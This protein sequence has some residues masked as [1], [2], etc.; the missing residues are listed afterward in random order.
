MSLHGIEELSPMGYAAI[1]GSG[2]RRPIGDRPPPPLEVPSLWRECSGI[3]L[4][5]VLL[6]VAAWIFSGC[7]AHV[8]PSGLDLVFAGSFYSHTDE[9]AEGEDDDPG[10]SQWATAAARTWGTSGLEGRIT[11]SSETISITGNGISDNLAGVLGED[12]IQA[13]AGAVACA[14]QPAQPRCLSSKLESAADLAGFVYT[15]NEM[16]LIEP[17]TPVPL[18][19][20]PVDVP[21]EP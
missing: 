10:S 11:E 18:E 2:D 5:F 9:Q 21:A 3:F 6:I 12:V 8:G 17:V 4:S 16:E 7:S 15:D 1:F 14:L 20:F 13:I 19:A